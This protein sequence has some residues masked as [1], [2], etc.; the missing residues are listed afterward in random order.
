MLNLLVFCHM[1]ASKQWFYDSF[2]YYLVIPNI[3]IQIFCVL[4]IKSS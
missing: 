3:Y 2:A 1:Y 4:T